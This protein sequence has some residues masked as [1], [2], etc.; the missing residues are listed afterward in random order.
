MGAALPFPSPPSRAN[1]LSRTDSGRLIVV[2]VTYVVVVAPSDEPAATVR[3]LRHAV[4]LAR[5][6]VSSAGAAT[7]R[8][9]RTLTTP[10]GPVRSIAEASHRWDLSAAG[11]LLLTVRQRLDSPATTLAMREVAASAWDCTP[12]ASTRGGPDRRAGRNRPTNV[13]D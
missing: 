4:H 10:A 1:M 8:R 2:R 9:Q 6:L 12:K 11:G 7:I 13:G 5:R 3:S